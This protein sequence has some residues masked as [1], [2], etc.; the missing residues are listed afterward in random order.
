MIEQFYTRTGSS[1]P[2]WRLSYVLKFQW[3]EI[4]NMSGL[5]QQS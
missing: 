2:W 3:K 1:V 4:Y 5:N